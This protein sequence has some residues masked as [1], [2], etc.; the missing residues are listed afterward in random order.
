MMA[1]GMENLEEVI[2]RVRV[3]L[4]AVLLMGVDVGGRDF[5]GQ[6]KTSANAT[7]GEWD[8]AV[9]S[10]GR[11]SQRGKWQSRAQDMGVISQ[12]GSHKSQ[13]QDWGKGQ[14]VT[15]TA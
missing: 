2:G 13:R 6:E 5:G 14:V 9:D 10:Q 8:Q 1:L 3:V 7:F 11:G 15:F 4:Q 12:V